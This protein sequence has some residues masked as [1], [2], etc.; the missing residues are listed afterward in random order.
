MLTFFMFV[1]ALAELKYFY[2]NR[3]FNKESKNQ[4]NVF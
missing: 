1:A 3:L 2:L 4:Q